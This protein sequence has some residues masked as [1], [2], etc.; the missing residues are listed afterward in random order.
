MA[1]TLIAIVLAMLLFFNPFGSNE[2]LN[3]TNLS[4]GIIL[5]GTFFLFIPILTRLM[6]W[7]PL[8]KAEQNLTPRVLDMW[9]MDRKLRIFNLWL[10]IFPLISF[11]F[12]FALP[13]LSS[14]DQ[15]VLLAT[16]II[17]AGIALDGIQQVMRSTM[18]YMNPFMVIQQLMLSGKQC[19]LEKRETDLLTTLDSLSEIAVKAIS[20][21]NSSLCNQALEG[22][23]DIIREFLIQAKKRGAESK[24]PVSDMNGQDKVSYTLFYFFQRLEQNFDQA[25][26]AKLEPICSQIISVLG[27]TA[28]AIAPYDMLMVEYP[29]HFIGKLASRAQN[30]GLQEVGIKAECTL[31]EITKIIITENDISKL[32]IK[33]P[34]LSMLRY[35][36]EMTKESFRLDKQL[37]LQVLVQPFRDLKELFSSAGI[38]SHPDSGIIVQDLDRI[39]GEFDALEQVLRTMPPLPKINVDKP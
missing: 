27:K 5:I 37:N 4:I 9:R 15:R 34:I 18:R 24:K 22:M 28:I 31:T 17:F 1:V 39:I 33:P 36:H 19:A 6:A 38:G 2:L 7:G 29:I 25:L 11:T 32:E 12:A 3:P 35:L 21:S 16:W 8:Q 23:L 14:F 20:R 26:A 10:F 13:T 30:Q